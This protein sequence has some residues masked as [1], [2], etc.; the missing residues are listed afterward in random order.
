ADLASELRAQLRASLPEYMVPAHFVVLDA[1]PLTENGKVDRKTLPLPF[2]P[3]AI[4][5]FDSSVPN[6][7]LEQA[8]ARIWQDV[9]T[10]DQV[11]ATDTFFDLGGHSL[12]CIRVVDRFE[13]ETGIRVVPL[14]LLNQTLR[15]IVA[16]IESRRGARDKLAQGRRAGI[17]SRLVGTRV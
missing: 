5:E 1:L 10:I 7:E 3:A 11:Y 13:R 12:L 9:L 4:G 2:R 8:M 17:L 16:G 6:G 15:Q 14:D